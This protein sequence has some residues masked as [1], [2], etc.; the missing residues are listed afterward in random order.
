M[1]EE[2]NT[3][4]TDVE[5]EKDFE[6]IRLFNK[7]D[8]SAF[9]KLIM[10]H[11]EKV[12]NLCYVTLGDSDSIDDIMQDVFINVYKHLDSFR[13]EAKFSTWLYRITVNK[14]R[15]FLRKKKVR[16]VFVPID[17]QYNLH[18]KNPRLDHEPDLPH[19]LNAAIERLPEKLK[20]PLIMRDV[21]GFSYKEI[22]EKL[23]LEIGTVKSRIFRARETLR[24]L[25]EPYRQD[26]L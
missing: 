13:F 24:A 5:N 1:L 4:N 6:L 23:E 22:A 19:L 16:S 25:L 26:R 7:G 18:S 14:C 17:N 12:K 8:E 21:E 9:T 10:R 20:L 2:K 15:D 3:L 11:K